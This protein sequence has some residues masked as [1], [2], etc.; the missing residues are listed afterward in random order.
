MISCVSELLVQEEEL[1]NVEPILVATIIHGFYGNED[2]LTQRT[3]TYPTTHEKELV[4][5]TTSQY[6]ICIY[7]L[8]C[9]HEKDLV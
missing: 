2:H 4:W 9:T 3:N 1:H 5:S 8:H 6:K 7:T